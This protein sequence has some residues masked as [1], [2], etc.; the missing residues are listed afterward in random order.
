MTNEK[1]D[2][3]LEKN[4]NV[5][6]RGKHGTGK[7]GTGKHGTGK[8]GTGKHGTG[9]TARVIDAFNRNK[10]KWKYFSAST[11]DPWVDFVGVPKE[12]TDANG[13]TFL[14]LVRPK[15]FA[16]DDVEAIMIDEYNRGAKKIKNAVMELIQFKSIN[17]K[18][19]KNL[20]VVWAAINPDEDETFS[21]D[22]E[23]MD[24][25]QLDRFHIQLDVPY[26]PELDYFVEKYGNDVGSG[27]C[28]WWN[29]QEDKIKNLVSPRRLDYA[30]SIYH[31]GG[32]LKDVLPEQVNAKELEK[33][34]RSG[35]FLSGLK[36]VL[37]KGK[38]NETKQFV[39]DENT[40]R[41]ISA[42]FDQLK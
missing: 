41:G 4:L 34:I 16:A 42:A 38:K 28:S 2:F 12:V 29:Q 23:K 27:A 24:P 25:A 20:R 31:Q 19:F 11:L 30:V 8:H 17:G 39:N 22:V 15:D 40:F 35:S 1:L 7:H 5:I 13:N 10:L 36:K 26:Q 14:D 37:S 6:L 32:D 21:Y 3:Y 18:K 33:H 9:K